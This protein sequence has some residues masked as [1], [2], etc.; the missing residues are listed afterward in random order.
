MRVLVAVPSARS[1]RM[2][3]SVL[4]M[5]IME[6]CVRVSCFLVRVEVFMAL[7]DMQPHTDSHKPTGHEEPSG[8]WV[9]EYRE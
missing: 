8:D 6:V 7:G 2:V 1:H 9:A 5:F 4:M 3:V